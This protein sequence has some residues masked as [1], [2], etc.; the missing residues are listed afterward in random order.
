MAGS[1]EHLEQGALKLL[2]QWKPSVKRYFLIQK[3]ASWADSL[4]QETA[5]LPTE[6][7]KPPVWLFALGA[8]VASVSVLL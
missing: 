6:P 8:G 2:R 3:L 5:P 4:R 7:L 1:R